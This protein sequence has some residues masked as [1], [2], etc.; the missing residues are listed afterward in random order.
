[1]ARESNPAPFRP[2]LSQLQSFV[3]TDTELPKGELLHRITG[4]VKYELLMLVK[5]LPFHSI[6]KFSNGELALV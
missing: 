5:L 1:M 4:K 3:E 6:R 2:D